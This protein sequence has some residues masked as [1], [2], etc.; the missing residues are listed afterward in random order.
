MSKASPNPFFPSLTTLSNLTRKNSALC[1]ENKTFPPLLI[2][3]PLYDVYAAAVVRRR[4][5]NQSL[6]PEMFCSSLLCCFSSLLRPIRPRESPSLSHRAP[7]RP[8][9]PA[10][11][12]NS[13]YHT[14]NISTPCLCICSG[15]VPTCS[16]FLINVKGSGTCVMDGWRIVKR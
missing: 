5:I 7:Q 3:I 6:D 16:D 1:T 4:Y 9:R 14:H 13:V 8:P 2:K 12:A 11:K 10:P 15:A